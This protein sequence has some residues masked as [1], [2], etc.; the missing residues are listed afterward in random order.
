[1]NLVSIETSCDETSVCLLKGRKIISHY[2][3]SQIDFHKKYGGVVPEVASRHHGAKIGELIKKLNI[4]KIDYVGFTRGPGLK[5]SLLIGKIA[6][7]VLADYFKCKIVGLNHLEGHLFSV[8]INGNNIEKK[9]KF[10]LIVLIVSG[11]HTELWY[12]NEIGKYD[13]IGRT[14]DDACGEAFD[15]VAKI[16]GLG[17]PGGPIIE[18]MAQTSI[19]KS[20]FFTVP[21]VKDSFDFSFSGIKTQ[22]AYYVRDYK[23]ITASHKADICYAFEDAAVKSLVKKL[24]LAV[25]KYKVKNIAICGGVSANGYLRKEILTKF[26]RTKYNIYFPDKKYSSDNAAMMGAALIEKIERKKIERDIEIDPDLK[27]RDWN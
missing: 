27:V 9:L 8:Q 20:S 15:K 4:K 26:D 3:Y 6:A 7:M 17:Y 18:K 22:V 25:K 23:K 16:L 11:G 13:I 5:G 12:S 19:K 2:V 24:D 14:R 1:M 21:E 10:P